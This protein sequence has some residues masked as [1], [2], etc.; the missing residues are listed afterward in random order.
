MLQ[1]QDSK[2]FRNFSRNLVLAGAAYHQRRGAREELDK[3]LE[4]M[5][6]SIIRMTL[7]YS[8]L[9]KLKGKISYKL[10]EGREKYWPFMG[11]EVELEEGELA[12][13]DE[14][15]VL[16][17][18]RYRDS[19]YAPVTP[20]TKNILVHIQGVNGIKK[21]LIGDALDELGRLVLENCGGK[22]VEKTIHE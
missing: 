14:E 21:E 17:L 22:I 11:E 13:F 2:W 6:K 16:G 18:V 20:D 9:D 5:R 7:T 15:K 10:S 1:Y 12:T 19:K 8:D 4:R 3:H